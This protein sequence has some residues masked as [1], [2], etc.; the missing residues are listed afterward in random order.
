MDSLE[1]DG[2]PRWHSPPANELL[3]CKRWLRVA[4]HIFYQCVKVENAKQMRK[5][6]KTLRAHPQLGNLVRSLHIS[7][8]YGIDLYAV[9]R[10]APHIEN[11]FIYPHMMSKDSNAGFIRALP[12]LKPKRLYVGS[13]YG[14]P[15]NVKEQQL[16]EALR[17]GVREWSTLV[18]LAPYVN[19]GFAKSHPGVRLSI[20]ISLILQ[21]G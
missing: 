8:G 20:E 15:H 1:Y 3:V 12:H 14:S 13:D 9:A 10:H 19:C 5:L 11:L 16:R 17:K 6:A 7:G 21:L 4:T 18:G 2:A